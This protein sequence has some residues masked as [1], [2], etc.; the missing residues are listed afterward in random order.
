MPGE[1]VET[2]PLAGMNLHAFR[3]DHALAFGRWLLKDR[4]PPRVTVFLIEA[5]SIEPGVGLS[6]P[7]E[8]AMQQVAA[9]LLCRYGAGVA[10]AEHG[11]IR[12]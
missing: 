7:V 5:Q 1:E 9:A 4:F 3:W 2:P 11:R 12:P 10:S 6:P 8:R